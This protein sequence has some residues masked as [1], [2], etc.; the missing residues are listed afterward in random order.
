MIILLYIIK[1]IKTY[2]KFQTNMISSENI[3]LN[4]IHSDKIPFNSVKILAS[5]WVAIAA[6]GMVIGSLN[7]IFK[8]M[9]NQKFSIQSMWNTSAS[10]TVSLAI[11]LMLALAVIITQI[12]LLS[13]RSSLIKKSYKVNQNY[14]ESSNNIDYQDIHDENRSRALLV[15]FTVSALIYITNAIFCLITSLKKLNIALDHGYSIFEYFTK[16]IINCANLIYNSSSNMLMG[17]D[18]LLNRNVNDYLVSSIF[19]FAMTII[20]LV[21]IVGLVICNYKNDQLLKESMEPPSYSKLN[22]HRDAEA[23]SSNTHRKGQ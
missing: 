13:Q 20:M 4:L 7:S 14:N 10:A 5:T 11:G 3:P 15:F 2:K 8:K 16:D 19:F 18:L 6:I 17:N 1:N 23:A 21:A 22:C 9:N 12:I